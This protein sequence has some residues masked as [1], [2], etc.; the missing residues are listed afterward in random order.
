VVDAAAVEK[1]LVDFETELTED[2]AGLRK[3]YESNI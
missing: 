1:R 3:V 2:L